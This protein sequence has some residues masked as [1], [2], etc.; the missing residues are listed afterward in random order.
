MMSFESCEIVR[1]KIKL[2]LII[3]EPVG[4]VLTAASNN[5]RDSIDKEL[6]AMRRKENGKDV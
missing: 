2:G 5:N 1:N 6:V 4:E 3:T